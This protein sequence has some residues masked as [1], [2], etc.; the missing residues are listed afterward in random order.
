MEKRQPPHQILPGKVVICLK[1]TET[2]AM[3]ITL[4][5]YQL[6]VV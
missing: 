5:Q 4:Y 6:K 2:A 3:P 1:K